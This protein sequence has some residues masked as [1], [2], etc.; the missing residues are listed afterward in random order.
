MTDFRKDFPILQDERYI[1]FD[2]AAT[3]QRPKQVMDAIADFYSATNANPL[4]GLYE[5]SVGAT[6]AYE[7]ARQKV[8]DF[9]G[10]ASSQ[11]IVFTRNASESLNLAAWC[12]S[13]LAIREGDEI[14]I[15]ITEHHSNLLPWQRVARETGA[16]LRFLECDEEGAYSDEEIA[17]KVGPKTKLIAI[18]Q[19]SNVLGTKNPVKK[20]ADL[21]HAN[22]GVIIVDGAQSAPHM[23]VNV[24]ELEA[25]FF[26]FSGHKMLGPMGIGV[27]YGRKELLEEMPPFL[28]GG[29]MIEFVTRED[30]TYAELP[31][32]FEAGTVNAAGAVGLAAAIDYLKNVG[33]EEIEKQEL[34][35]TTQLLEEMRKLPYMTV[36]GSS[37]PANHCGIVSFNIEGCHPHDVS[38][39]LDMDHVCIRAGHHCAQ[40]LMQYMNVGSTC[41]ASLYFYNTEEEVS[42]FMDSIRKV[43][44]ELGYQD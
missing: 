31:H 44:S 39:I 26:A 20:L 9:I 4:R 23:A 24:R 27:L 10:A 16:V 28:V 17:S 2:N 21:V 30:A 43:R 35:L 18:G 34:K 1:Y 19:V 3:S 15:G 11:E 14:V 8:A 29:E 40:P 7:N 12:Y 32:K 25:D 37:D 38:S 36:Y 5:W 6:D 41:R 22:G 42:R 13:R 33:F